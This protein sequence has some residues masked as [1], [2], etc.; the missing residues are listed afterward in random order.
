MLI[1]TGN[2]KWANFFKYTEGAIL[3]IFFI[4]YLIYIYNFIK[5]KEGYKIHKLHVFTISLSFSEVIF[6][7]LSIFYIDYYLFT[8]LINLLK[9][10]LNTIL[11]CLVLVIL[12]F[13]LGFNNIKILNY[14]FFLIF[15]IDIL[16]FLIALNKKNLFLVGKCKTK[17]QLSLTIIGLIFDIFIILSDVYLSFQKNIETNLILIVKEEDFYI[18][19]VAAS[20]VRRVKQF[21]TNYIILIAIF[22]LSFF[23]EISFWLGHNNNIKINS[24]ININDNDNNNDINYQ[25]KYYGHLKNDFFFEEY[26]LCFI[27]FIL[28]DIFPNLFIFIVTLIYRWE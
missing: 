3:F 6:Q 10:T 20:F 8:L 12:M 18:N 25:C 26:Y 16:V 7:L 22:L 24:N 19:H 11:C 28:R 13:K 4:S 1:C 5:N 14:I 21:Y 17:T 2:T 27:G 9:F 15:I 23:I